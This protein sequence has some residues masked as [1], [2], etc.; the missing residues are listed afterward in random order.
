M[1]WV[2]T[3]YSVL[4]VLYMACFTFLP[5]KRF[6]ILNKFA[7]NKC[8]NKITQWSRTILQLRGK[9]A[10][11]ARFIYL[12]CSYNKNRLT[13]TW[14]QCKLQLHEVVKTLSM[15]YHRMRARSL[16]YWMQWN[17]WT[18]SWRRPVFPCQ[19]DVFNWMWYWLPGRCM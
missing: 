7:V 2:S 5:P 13:N 6:K 4:N 8:M 15:F 9:K 19:R 1:C 11:W 14:K 17:M 16:W 10:S 3:F 12:G 18:L